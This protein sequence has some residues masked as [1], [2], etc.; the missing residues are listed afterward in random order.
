VNTG[1]D[2]LFF[3]LGI[4]PFSF[5]TSRKMSTHIMLHILQKHVMSAWQSFVNNDGNKIDNGF[6][7]FNTYRVGYHFKLFKDRIFIQPSIAVTHRPF[8]TD[9]PESFK[10]LDDKRSKF[11]FGEPG[12]HFGV[13][14]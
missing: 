14:F 9:M 8:H 2:T 11:F 4:I 1:D 3:L 10:Q 13:N 7:I 6:Q 5:V 12:L